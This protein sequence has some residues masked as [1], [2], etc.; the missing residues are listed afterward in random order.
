VR[1]IANLV[2]PYAPNDDMHGTSAALEFGVMG[3]GVEYIVVM[4]HAGCGGVRAFV[5]GEANA[6]H[7]PLSPGD[8]IGKWISLINPAATRIEP[9]GAP[10]DDY[11]ERLALASIVQGLANLRTFPWIAE[12]EQQGKLGLHGA[13]FGISTGIL[14]AL[15]EV[16]GRFEPIAAGAHR[17]AFAGPGS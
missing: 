5:R 3:L 15:D 16:S 2:P 17:N 4:G 11:I 8:F 1:N 13:Y 10:L 6:G 9:A 7:E 14:L 12:R